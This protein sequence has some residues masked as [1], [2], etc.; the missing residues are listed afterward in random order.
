MTG[1]ASITTRRT[2][3]TSASVMMET[4]TPEMRFRNTMVP[5][6]SAIRTGKTNPIASPNHSL[7]NGN[8]RND[9]LVMQHSSVGAPGSA[10]HSIKSGTGLS[11]PCCRLVVLAS[12]SDIAS[13]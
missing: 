6:T 2:S 9:A 10:F 7:W 1:W 12:F 13:M 8:Q 4:N 5:S 3:S 11:E